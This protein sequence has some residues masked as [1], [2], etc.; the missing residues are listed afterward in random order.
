MPLC[1]GQIFAANPLPSPWVPLGLSGVRP[2]GL[3]ADACITEKRIVDV[4]VMVPGMVDVP[5]KGRWQYK[6][7]CPTQETCPLSSAE[8]P[9]GFQGGWRASER[10]EPIGGLGKRLV[11]ARG[12]SGLA[13]SLSPF[14]SLS[15]PLRSREKLAQVAELETVLQCRCLR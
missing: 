9:K 4:I 10:N 15:K 5:C 2:A 8:V 11:S 7:Q 1:P 12:I 3:I 13:L 14:L 6:H